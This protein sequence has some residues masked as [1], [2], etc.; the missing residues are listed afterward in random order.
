MPGA[1]NMCACYPVSS[2]SSLLAMAS[3]RRWA[4]LGVVLLALFAMATVYRRLAITQEHL[5]AFHPGAKPPAAARVAKMLAPVVPPAAPAAPEMIQIASRS[6][7]PAGGVYGRAVA[8]VGGNLGPASVVLS[9]S[10]A[11]WLADRWQIAG[12]MSGSP[13]PV[14]QWIAI[15]FMQGDDQPARF[16]VDHLLLD[17]ETA[18]ASEYTLELLD[19]TSDA[20]GSA[21]AWH[22]IFFEH[23]G[24]GGP[25]LHN[26]HT[27]TA[28][29]LKSSID[30]DLC[31]TAIRLTILC[32]GTQWGSSLW[33]FL[34]YGKA[35]K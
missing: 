21:G 17:W 24:R 18:F 8:S 2:S 28:G 14:P 3:T 9:E 4:L 15:H 1:D 22:T 31:G 30:S 16:C 33:R 35:A 27:I 26:N 32:N 23:A 25:G 13:L 11:D 12:D 6:A 5:P 29:Q 10:V 20:P 19:G 34:V 7:V